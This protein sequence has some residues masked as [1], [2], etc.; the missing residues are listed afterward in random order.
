MLLLEHADIMLAENSQSALDKDSNIVLVT[1]ALEVH[2]GL[3]FLTTNRVLLLDA[4]LLARIDLLL[5]VL[6]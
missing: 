2:R 5:S 6:S 3:V 1:K 4:A